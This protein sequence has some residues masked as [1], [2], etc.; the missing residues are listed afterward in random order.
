MVSLLRDVAKKAARAVFFSAFLDGSRFPRPGAGDQ[1]GGDNF[2][3]RLGYP[4]GVGAAVALWSVKR[5]GI[6]VSHPRIL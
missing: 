3:T 5:L 4:H 2:F 6:A 1:G